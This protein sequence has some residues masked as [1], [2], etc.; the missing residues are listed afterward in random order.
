M[1]I[2]IRCMKLTLILAIIIVALPALAQEDA[3]ATDAPASKKAEKPKPPSLVAITLRESNPSTPTELMR[4]IEIL[5]DGDEYEEVKVYLGKLIASTPDEPSRAALHRLVGSGPFFRISRHQELWPQGRI[6]SEAVIAAGQ[7]AASEPQQVAKLVAALSQPEGYQSALPELRAAGQVAIAPLVQALADPQRAADK[8]RIQTALVFLSNDAVEPLIGVLQSGNEDLIAKVIPVLGILKAKRAGPYL[9]R[10]YVDPSK[11]LAT[12][13]AAYDALHRIYNVRPTRGEAL[14]LLDREAKAFAAGK[15]PLT[16]DDEDS[17]VLWNWD[18]SKK[19]SVPTRLRASDSS[20]VVAATLAVDNAAVQPNRKDLKQQELLLRLA[21]EKLIGGLDNPLPSGAGTVQDEL[22][23]L[24]AEYVEGVLIRALEQKAPTACMA[25]VEVLGKIA[26]ADILKGIGG[27]PRA[28]AQALRHTDRRVRFAAAQAIFNIDPQEGY[29]GAS[30]LLD[31]LEY[32]VS[33]HGRRRVLI[34]HP[35]G[36]NA[37]R[38]FALL[39]Q[40]GYE[41]ETSFIGSDLYRKAVHSADFEAIFV[42]DGIDR[43]TTIELISQLRKDYRTKTMAIALLSRES[44]LLANRSRFEAD[45]Y[46]EVFPA[47]QD[48]QAMA[49]QINLL[50]TRVDREYVSPEVRVQ[51]AQASLRWL[52]H[53]ASDA[54]IYPQYDLLTRESEIRKALFV[55]PLTKDTSKF[56]AHM[57]TA[58][59]QRALVTFASQNSR[60][61]KQRQAAAA[62]FA[63]AAENRELLLNKADVLLQYERYNQSEALDVDTQNL[64]SQILDVIEGPVPPAKEDDQTAK[65]E[66]PPAE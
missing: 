19:Q 43:P 50:R 29:P 36:V 60:P 38:L 39:V 23:N 33:T 21:A 1:N 64:L 58:G 40:L 65:A 4:A 20:R 52:T 51:Q 26:N 42:S 63:I 18:A 46:C 5:L 45:H 59:A 56:L 55:G 54:S 15:L 11:Q 57:G 22:K 37:Q 31:A 49:Y 2:M 35:K 30:Y 48:A 28:L 32:F 6:F 10:W 17:V 25:A 9:L 12:R 41:P 66:Q 14:V 34:G 16:T 13:K 3:S 62:A 44:R 27:Q 53:F 61:I 8:V 47:A 7:K 24:G